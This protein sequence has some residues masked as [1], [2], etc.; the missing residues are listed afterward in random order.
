MGLHLTLLSGGYSARK[1]PGRSCWVLPL[2]DGEGPPEGN[3]S[4]QNQALA[5]PHL[6][7]QRRCSVSPGGPSPSAPIPV[8]ND[9]QGPPV[10][11]VAPRLLAGGKR[12]LRVLLSK[13]KQP[14]PSTT[15]LMRGCYR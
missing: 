1:T 15:S 8:P 14:A 9:G 10:P 3:L 5:Q 12:G 6:L 4:P 11:S 13:V 2:G 7:C